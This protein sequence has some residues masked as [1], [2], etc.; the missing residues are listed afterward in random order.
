MNSVRPRES[1]HPAVSRCW[2][3]TFAG[4]SGFANARP[5]PVFY[6]Q[7]F[8]RPGATPLSILLGGL[9]MLA[10]ALALWRFNQR[11]GRA[12]M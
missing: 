11:V 9:V 2:I 12:T 6:M 4:M 10:I 3:P 5:Y 7:W 1:G 8:E